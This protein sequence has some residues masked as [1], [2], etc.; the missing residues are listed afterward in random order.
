MIGGA[1]TRG[2]EAGDNLCEASACEGQKLG[3]L[4]PLVPSPLALAFPLSGN[5]TTQTLI[6]STNLLVIVQ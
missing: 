1:G 6:S 4:A 5:K 2:C 3:G